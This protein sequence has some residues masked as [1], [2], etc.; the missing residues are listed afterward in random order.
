[1]MKKFFFDEDVDNQ[2]KV[3]PQTTINTNMVQAMKKLQA[4]YNDDANKFI[5]EAT[6]DKAIKN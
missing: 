6:Q 2:V 5:K 1:M 3:S 4:L